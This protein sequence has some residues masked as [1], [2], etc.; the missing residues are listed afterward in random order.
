MKRVINFALLS[1]LFLPQAPLGAEL[2]G[3]GSIAAQFLTSDNLPL[4]NGIAFLYDLTTG[5]LPSKDRYWRVPDKAII[6][7][8][9]GRL[10]F[11]L[12]P[13]EYS[14]A[15]IKRNAHQVGPPREGELFILATDSAGAPLCFMLNAN[16]RLDLGQISGALP[17]KAFSRDGV[18]AFE[19]VVTDQHGV[20]LEGALVFA[21]ASPKGTGKP[22]FVSDRTGKGGEFILRVAEGGTYYLKVRNT[23]GGGPP[24][25]GEAIDGIRNEP[26]VAASVK[27]GEITKGLS[28][29]SHR[30]P[31]R[32]PG[33]A[34]GR[35]PVEEGGVKRPPANPGP[36]IAPW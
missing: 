4:A 24:K 29:K 21:F 2:P 35:G 10:K 11:T 30:F 28:L 1:L 14:L 15:G 12:P 19:G 20:K 13:G 26:L 9:E 8:H 23:Y 22:M 18:T 34:P 25:A 33:T 27:R 32:G 31:G 36:G 5:P 6:L 16:Q 17:F 7:D 3:N